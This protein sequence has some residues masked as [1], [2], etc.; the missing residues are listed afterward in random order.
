[1]LIG[2]ISDTHGLLRPEVFDVFAGVDRILHAGD[3]GRDDGLLIELAA[4]APVDAVHGNT[5]GFPLRQKLPESRTLDLQ[6][7]VVFLAHICGGPTQLRRHWPKL[8]KI[9]VVV[10]GHTHK[11]LNQWDNGVLFFNPGSAG[12]RRFSLPISLGLLRIE[13]SRVEG[14]IVILRP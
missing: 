13:T 11:P 9:D 2:V 10:F 1:M 12:P 3:V 5:D 6:G 7:V 8:G 4:L 14:Q